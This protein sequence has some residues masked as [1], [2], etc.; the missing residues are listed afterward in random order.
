MHWKA[1][2]DVNYMALLCCWWVGFA[3]AI[4]QLERHDTW[5]SSIRDT[6]NLQIADIN[7]PKVL[8]RHPNSDSTILLLLHFSIS[9]L[10]YLLWGHFV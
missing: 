8:H 2:Y 7:W 6:K 4:K 10:L 5:S 9:S 3:S 1:E